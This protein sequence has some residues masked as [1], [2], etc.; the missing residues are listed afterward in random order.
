MKNIKNLT[1]LKTTNTSDS[2]MFH[3]GK[4][5]IAKIGLTTPIFQITFPNKN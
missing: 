1:I 5:I 2:L 4:K 3:H